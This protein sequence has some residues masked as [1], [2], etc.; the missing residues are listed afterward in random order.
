MTDNA[1]I[2]ANS[3]K[4]SIIV[5]CGP[6]GIGKTAAAIEIAETFGGEIISAD[7]MQV[8]RL[9]DIGTA[10]PTVQ[11]QARIR[12]HLIDIVDPDEDFDAARFGSLARP[13]IFALIRKNKLPVVAGGT[14][15]YIKAL[16]HG[17][18]QARPPAPEIR[19]KLKD[20]AASRGPSALHERLGRVDPQAA[21]GIHPNDV[22]RIIRALET[23]ELTGRP[24]SDHHRIHGFSE[25]PFQAFKIGLTMDR[26][27]LYER[28][29]RRV[30]LMIA[31]GLLAEVKGLLGKG[32]AENL[33]AMQSIG[34][35]H[36][37]DYLGGRLSWE[38][39]VRT[40]K[41]DTRRYAKRQLTWFRA[42]PDISWVTPTELQNIYPEIHR[43]LTVGAP[44]G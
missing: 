17:L 14:G 41:R 7:S 25:S 23:Y 3:N 30:D 29:N 5:V 1:L 38:E 37:A 26:K 35:R 31:A 28:I 6:T 39:S 16:I 2:E 43:F 8:Y 4:P 36:M 40:L 19:R 13:L 42:D 24:I 15:L 33:K 12:H 27:A 18:F 11:E 34:Y 21:A 32:Y 10:K 44:T 22:F 20:E 9:M